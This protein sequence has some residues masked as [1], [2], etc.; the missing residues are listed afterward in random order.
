MEMKSDAIS[1]I[2][3]IIY[4]KKY[5][6]NEQFMNIINPRLKFSTMS[7]TCIRELLLT[8]SCIQ[9]WRG[10]NQHHTCQKDVSKVA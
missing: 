4:V 7:V 5:W 3:W 8:K 10:Y 9:G 1:T 6:G 2:S